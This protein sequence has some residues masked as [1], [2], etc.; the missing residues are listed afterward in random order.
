MRLKDGPRVPADNSPDYTKLRCRGPPDSPH[1]LGC[2]VGVAVLTTSQPHQNTSCLPPRDLAIAMPQICRIFTSSSQF[3]HGSSN[4][5]FQALICWISPSG[6]SCHDFLEC[7]LHR[8]PKRPHKNLG[9]TSSSNLSAQQSP[10][11]PNDL[12]PP[13]PQLGLPFLHPT[14]RLTFKNIGGC[15]KYHHQRWQE[16][17]LQHNA[18]E[19]P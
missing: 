13:F 3:V 9:L 5:S 17:Q 12:A 14:A 8:H 16:Q 4:K 15:R 1:Q 18:R 10:P 11:D 6:N 19:P 2:L 7:H